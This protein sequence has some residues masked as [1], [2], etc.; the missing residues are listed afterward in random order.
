MLAMELVSDRDTR[1]H[2]E[3]ETVARVFEATYDAGAMVRLSGFNLIM[4]PPLT[5]SADDCD[6]I[7]AA[8]DSGFQAA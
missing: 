3:K 4:S 1:A 8:L 5:I 6:A 7:L 2:T